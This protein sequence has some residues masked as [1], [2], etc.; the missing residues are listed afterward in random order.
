LDIDAVN[1]CALCGF[2]S[3]REL[4]TFSEL[5]RK[6]GSSWFLRLSKRTFAEVAMIFCSTTCVIADFFHSIIKLLAWRKAETPRE[7]RILKT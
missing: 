3:I 6:C 1:S 4:S 5:K 7:I 2:S